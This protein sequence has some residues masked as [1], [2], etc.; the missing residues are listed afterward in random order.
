MMLTV[1]HKTPEIILALD[2]EKREQAEKILQATGNKLEWVKVGLQSYLR[3]GP[4]LVRTIAESG[5]KVFLDLKL[6]DIPN[7]MA[8]AM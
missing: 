2:V 5:K 1:T 7:T 4:D 8:K 3:D 6:H